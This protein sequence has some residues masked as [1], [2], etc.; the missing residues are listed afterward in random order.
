[1]RMT[2]EKPEA[3]SVCTKDGAGVAAMIEGPQQLKGPRKI[4][5]GKT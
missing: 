3:G 1:M 5:G 4:G 2:S